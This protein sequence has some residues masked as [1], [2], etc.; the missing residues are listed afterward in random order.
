[1]KV[2]GYLGFV[3]L[4]S[5][6]ITSCASASKIDGSSLAAF[7]HSHAA[8]IA[9]L[10]PEDRVRLTL[11]ELIVLSPKNCLTTKP[12]PGQP[13]LNNYLGG[14][15]D[16]SSCR[17]ELHGLTFKDIMSQAYPQGEPTGGDGSGAA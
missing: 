4:L 12:L 11:A 10:S 1:M 15:A 5:L 17:K 7:E 9:S 6:A 14:Q 3:A 13:F 8:L 2:L 16:L